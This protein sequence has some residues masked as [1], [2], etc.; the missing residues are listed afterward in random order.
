MKNFLKPL[1]FLPALFL[2]YAIWGFSG[3]TGEESS[4]L[5]GRVSL[6]L[7]EMAA[8]Y[9][10]KDTTREKI[11]YFGDKMELAV[12]KGAH[13]SEY[14]VLAIALSFPLYVYGLEGLPLIVWT[15]WISVG[16]ACLDEYRQTF[17][18]GRDGN[19]RDVLIDAIGIF[20]GIMFVR[21]FLWMRR[22]KSIK[23]GEE[24]KNRKDSCNR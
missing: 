19:I 7:A 15:G 12:R 18:P 6:F 24:R 23:D 5:S 20:A 8:E 2:M 10:D 3:Q 17:V 22:K 14:L 11:Q 16:F 13:I 4:S 1:S 21:L 9:S